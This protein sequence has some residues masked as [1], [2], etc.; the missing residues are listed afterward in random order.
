MRHN[1]LRYELRVGC[2]KELLLLLLPSQTTSPLLSPDLQEVY[3]NN[4]IKLSALDPNL[5]FPISPE[6]F[7][8]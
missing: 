8:A 6:A 2:K 5:S 4:G 1:R 3:C 7:S